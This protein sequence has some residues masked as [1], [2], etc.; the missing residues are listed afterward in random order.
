M[1]L[2]WIAMVRYCVSTSDESDLYHCCVGVIW[3]VL[4]SEVCVDEIEI[5]STGLRRVSSDCSHVLQD[6]I[7]DEGVDSCAVSGEPAVRLRSTAGKVDLSVALKDPMSRRGG[8]R[9]WAGCLVLLL[10]LR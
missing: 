8:L 5:I 7:L 10:C 4:R 1:N 6:R 3:P 9:R 2:V